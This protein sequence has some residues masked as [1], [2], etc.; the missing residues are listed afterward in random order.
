MK[1]SKIYANN[2]G[3]KSII[4]TDG[5]NVIYGNIEDKKDSTGKVY[6]H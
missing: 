4:F 1:L 5:L 2:Q 6:E 3:F